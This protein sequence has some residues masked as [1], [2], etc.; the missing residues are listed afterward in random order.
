MNYLSLV[1]SLGLLVCLLSSCGTQHSTLKDFPPLD[2]CRYEA[3]VAT[4]HYRGRVETFSFEP[5]Y[6]RGRCNKIVIDV[7]NLPILGGVDVWM[8]PAPGALASFNAYGRRLGD[9][10]W[11]PI[12]YSMR[13]L[14]VASGPVLNRFVRFY[15]QYFATGRLV[16]GALVNGQQAPITVR[17]GPAGLNFD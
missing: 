10:E 13:S 15:G 6:G 11:L 3:A 1:G 5:P 12:E 7:Y 2:P 14:P 17:V 8:I 4:V 16:V 9:F